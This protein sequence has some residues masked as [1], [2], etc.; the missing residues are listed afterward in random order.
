MLRVPGA[1]SDARMTD[2]LTSDE[3]EICVG[4]LFTRISVNG[5]DYYF[6]RLSGKLDG[7]GVGCS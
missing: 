6:R 4:P 7:S 1:L 2:A 3:I 5:R